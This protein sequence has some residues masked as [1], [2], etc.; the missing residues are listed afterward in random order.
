M[1]AV[2]VGGGLLVLAALL[3]LTISERTVIK[4]ATEA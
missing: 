2:T 3:T 1:A 4:G